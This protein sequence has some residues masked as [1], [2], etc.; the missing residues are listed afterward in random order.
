MTM[1]PEA[2]TAQVACEAIANNPTA[3][4]TSDIEAVLHTAKYAGVSDTYTEALKVHR[5]K[6]WHDEAYGGY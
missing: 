4:N 2:I 6:A 1:S 5:S 3:Y